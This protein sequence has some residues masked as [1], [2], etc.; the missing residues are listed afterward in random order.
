[1]KVLSTQLLATVVFVG[2]AAN[3]FAQGGRAVQRQGQRGLAPEGGVT[4]AEIQQMFDAYFLVQAQEVLQLKDEQ[5]PRFLTRL[6]ALQAIR[7]R[8]ENQRLQNLNQLRR[9]LQATD[10]RVDDSLIKERLKTLSDLDASVA[11]E[12]RQAQDSLD[13]VLDLRQQARF[14]ILEEEM[15]RRKVELV[16]RTRQANRPNPN[17]PR[18]PQP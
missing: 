10:G 14:R 4:P 1:M 13:E 16:M 9:M 6:R 12:I 11:T 18:D 2:L 15:E 7:R 3:A 5:Y 8:A 17:R